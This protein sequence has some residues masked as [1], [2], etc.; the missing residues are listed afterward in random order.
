MKNNK[1]SI[2]Q[3]QN[4]SKLNVLKDEK[5][6]QVKGGKSNFVII[7]DIIDG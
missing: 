4:N 3:L 7:V 5:A 1:K 6:K 2:T